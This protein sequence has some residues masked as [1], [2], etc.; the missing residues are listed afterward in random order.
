MSMVEYL[1][2]LFIFIP[3]VSS[4]QRM[5]DFLQSAKVPSMSEI[6]ICL[7]IGRLRFS[8]LHWTSKNSDL[9]LEYETISSGENPQSSQRQITYFVISAKDKAKS[10]RSGA[11]F[12]TFL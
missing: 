10:V 8:I 3:L 9:E 2:S 1:S 12:L 7:L 4:N 6:T 5:K 11:D